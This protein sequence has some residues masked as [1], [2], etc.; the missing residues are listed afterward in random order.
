M[1]EIILA[2]LIAIVFT[3]WGGVWGTEMG[4]KHACKSV[5]M[6]LVVDKCM[7]VTREDVK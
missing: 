7:K 4:A 1:R 5:N 2:V 6:E 3:V